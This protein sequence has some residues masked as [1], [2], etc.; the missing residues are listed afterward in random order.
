MVNETQHRINHY[1]PEARVYFLD[2]KWTGSGKLREGLQVKVPEVRDIISINVSL[3]ITLQPGTFTIVLNNKNER[4]FIKDNPEF[5][6][7]NLNEA[8]F[9]LQQ[10]TSRRPKSMYPYKN[11]LEWLNHKEF[12]R[13]YILPNGETV[14]LERYQG[15]GA[16]GYWKKAHDKN[17]LKE[18]GKENLDRVDQFISLSGKDLENVV[19]SS[20]SNID[21]YADCGG[22]LEQ[23][24]CI[25]QPM[26]RIVILLSK[27]FKTEKHPYDFIDVFTGIVNFVTEDY[28]ENFSK[29]T[30]SGEDVTKWLRV[31]LANV[32][33]SILTEKM[34][35]AGPDTM[36]TW[37]HRFANMEP[38]EIIRL[39]IFG[40]SDSDNVKL[41]GVGDFEYDPII[42]PHTSLL[43]V[44]KGN[45]DNINALTFDYS[46]TYVNQGTQGSINAAKASQNVLTER[47]DISQLDKLFSTPR[48]HIQIPTEKKQ[49]DANGE[50]V[51]SPYKKFVNS[52]YGSYENEYKTHLDIIHE[53]TKTTFFEFYADQ[54][55]D[56]WYHQPRFDNL[57]ILTADIPE[58]YI[59]QNE[60]ILNYNFAETDDSIITSVLITGQQDYIEGDQYPL[61]LVNFYE[62][63]SLILKYGRRMI[64]LSH[65]F[66]RTSEDCYYYA[67]SYLLRVLAERRTGS[68]TI[69]GRPELRMAMPVYIPFKNM[70]YYVNSITH[71]FTYGETFTTTL[72]L[73][74]GRKPWEP[75]PELLT[76]TAQS[77]VDGE[78]S[79]KYIS[80]ASTKVHEAVSSKYST[81]DPLSWPL[82][83]VTYV[84]E[85]GYGEKIR[86]R[87]TSQII[88]PKGLDLKTEVTTALDVYATHDGK[89]KECDIDYVI[90]E[91]SGGTYETHYYG[92]LLTIN[93]KAGSTITKDT[94]IGY[95]QGALRYCM[96][97]KEGF[98]NPEAYTK[99]KLKIRSGGTS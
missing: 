38:W 30:I 65:P 44:T 47:E 10:N 54:N 53:L 66:V 84:L 28:A 41:R 99:E 76:Y 92:L 45:K 15:N 34:P 55:G 7:A 79:E 74:Y 32:N 95:V 87:S 43:D 19:N 82:G 93:I 13:L 26:D 46:S 14:T 88:L 40:G 86:Y 80:K 96:K 33:P 70:I 83:S 27:R 49:Y 58:V 91:S 57:H 59:I 37:S 16:I 71:N 73:T 90:I 5:E 81:G 85:A 78:V 97:R 75:L 36:R 29:L 6:I 4:Y 56:I 60:D 35:D 42:G 63:K 24:R 68:I 22:M 72:G 77:A 98:V 61:N 52:S 39:L 62:D 23:G 3:N 67:Q 31:T 50:L 89:V 20:R 17:W 69:V 1:F 9:N 51:T 8:Q 25:F 21:L 64:T 18:H 12:K 11:A 48:V 2:P 94:Q